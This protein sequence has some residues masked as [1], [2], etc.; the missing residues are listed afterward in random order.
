M[1]A[2]ECHDIIKMFTLI[3]FLRQP[4]KIPAAISPVAAGIFILITYGRN[5]VF[6]LVFFPKQAQSNLQLLE[7]LCFL[8]QENHT[9]LN[10]RIVHIYLQNHLL[11]NENRAR[12]RFRTN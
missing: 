1:P 8:L 6:S 7:G 11:K 9:F 10:R 3:A 4:F 12:P 2:T 5:A